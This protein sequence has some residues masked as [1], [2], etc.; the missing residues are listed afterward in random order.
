MSNAFAAPDPAF[1]DRVV[2]AHATASQHFYESCERWSSLDLDNPFDSLDAAVELL[3]RLF[4]CLVATRDYQFVADEETSPLLKRLLVLRTEIAEARLARL[5]SI[6]VAFLPES[7][8]PGEIGRLDELEAAV[9]NLLRAPIQD[10]ARR[11]ATAR[12]WALHRR[13]F[14]MLRKPV[15]VQI[16]HAAEALRGQVEAD[17]LRDQSECVR[18]AYTQYRDALAALTADGTRTEK[19]VTYSDAHKYLKESEYEVKPE[20]TWARYVRSALQALGL[21]RKKRLPKYEGR[22]AVPRSHFGDRDD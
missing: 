13:W 17:P 2:A 3:D 21:Q 15:P 11:V 14:P 1:R 7:L 6:A 12:L 9:W 8:L 4:H 5:R 19:E 20:E 22:S 18:I 10:D 16:P